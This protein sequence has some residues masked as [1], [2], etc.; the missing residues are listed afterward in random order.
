MRKWNDVAAFVA[1]AD[2]RI[3][4]EAKMGRL[5]Y[6]FR[7]TDP[8]MAGLAWAAIGRDDL[9]PVINRGEEKD[10]RAETVRKIRTARTSKTSALRIED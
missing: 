7:L 9:S 5:P 8:E 3:E 10:K 2:D 4:G 1:F 6:R